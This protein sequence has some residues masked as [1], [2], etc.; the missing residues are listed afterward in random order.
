MTTKTIPTGENKPAGRII[1]AERLFLMRRLQV[2]EEEHNR[3]KHCDR[4]HRCLH[5]RFCI[6]SDSFPAA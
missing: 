6:E 3:P 1:H 4:H 5:C 2:E